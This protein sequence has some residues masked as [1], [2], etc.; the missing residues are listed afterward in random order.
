[1][2]EVKTVSIISLKG[3][4]YPTWK[5]QCRMALIRE[6][7][8][9]IVA[10]TEERPDSTD[11]DKLAKYLVRRD[12]ALSTIVLAVDPSLLYLLGDPED[13]KAVWTRLS[14]Q[15][16]KKTWANKFSLRRQLFTMKLTDAGCMAEYIKR[17][18]EIFA[19][20][21]V[22][23]E[24][25]SDEDK[26]VYLLASLPPSYDVLVTA[27]ESGSDT[28]PALETVTERLLREEQQ[29]MKMEKQRYKDILHLSLL[30]EAWTFQEGLPQ[31]CP[32]KSGEKKGKSKKSHEAMIISNALVARSRSDWI[33][34]SGATSHMC[35]DR[36]MFTQLKQLSSG[37][38]VALAAH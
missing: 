6:G 22:I 11:A 10:G 36:S 8:W 7:L 25:I 34:D 31:V 5:V 16:Q 29:L 38:K 24:P 33:V 15:F 35:N 21:A 1:M 19:E 37:D 23:S 27:L 32:G 3:T 17:M 2:A 12:R 9:G 28:V 20:L 26:V 14:G 4:N 30:Q 13:P 18:T